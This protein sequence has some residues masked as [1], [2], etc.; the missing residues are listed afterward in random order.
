M[1]LQA[2]SDVPSLAWTTLAILAALKSRERAPWA[3]AAGAAIAIDVLLRPTNILAFV[4]AAIVLGAS[5]RR[6]LFFIA[7][8]LPGA[9]FLGIHS[10]VAY[11]SLATTGYGDHLLEFSAG[12][13]HGTL[14]H[15]ALWLPVL[16]TP[17]V[18][19]DLGLPWL[20]SVSSR[21]R[22]ILVTWI[23]AYGA[24][25]STYK[26]T[27]ETWWYLRFLL[28]AAPALVI[29]GMLVA[30]ALLS[31]LPALFDP[32]RSMAAFVVV[33]LLVAS[34]SL[35]RSHEVDA[36]SVGRNELRYGRVADWM[37]GNVPKDAVC[38]TMQASGALFYYTDFTFIRWDA[39]DQ[40]NV[41]AVEA[42]V[43]AVRT[44]P[45]TPSSS[46]LRCGISGILDKTDPGSLA[47]GR[48]GQRH[49]DLAPRAR[50][51]ETL[52]RRWPPP[53]SWT[54]PTR[55]TRGRA[56]EFNA[57]RAR[58]TVN[59]RVEPAPVCLDPYE[60]TWRPLEDWE[61][62][63]L[64][65]RP[66]LP[67]AGARAGR[68]TRGSLEACGACAAGR[69]PLAGVAGR[70]PAGRRRASSS[71]KSSRP[72]SPPRCPPSSPPAQGPASHYFTTP[73]PSSSP[74]ARRAPRWHA[75]QDT[76]ASCWRSTGSP[77]CPRIP[78]RPWRTTGAGSAPGEDPP[79]SRS[80]D[81]WTRCPAS[82]RERV[83]RPPRFPRSFAS[84]AS[85]PGKSPRG[86]P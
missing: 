17:I 81:S 15:Y 6:W 85:R 10:L 55:A 3:L 56:R 18:V 73:S 75:F 64:R 20:S 62:A 35:W 32:A 60:R 45:S 31:R 79:L 37:E 40:G 9:V 30:R 53:F 41:G 84:G 36:L 38:L 42:A 51:G 49:H 59:S 11:G 69:P 19:L 5:P 80:G 68:W 27:H 13:I 67:R 86:A 82:A 63:N 71:R 50:S 33:F 52:T 8:G 39:L 34:S 7:G 47:P 65:T 16:F 58:S 1:S 43:R 46:H 78:A 74:N 54:S 12:F 61:L 44:A 76:C 14:I 25:Y 72:G 29:G 66:D 4:P 21:T 23:A 83:H 2:M 48:P 70:C 22:W 26:C 57:S 77:P 24:F 28:P